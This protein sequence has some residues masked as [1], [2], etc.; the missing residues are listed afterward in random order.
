[1]LLFSSP[2]WS[3]Q[4]GQV[5]PT[6]W[7]T[8][9]TH[10]PTIIEDSRKL[11]FS[12]SKQNFIGVIFSIFTCSKMERSFVNCRR[13][14]VIPS[15]EYKRALIYKNQEEYIE[16]YNIE[17]V[18]PFTFGSLKH[19]IIRMK[20]VPFHVVIGLFHFLANYTIFPNIPSRNENVLPC[21]CS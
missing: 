20:K 5:K 13:V 21:T 1:M 7:G 12:L 16:S 15:L 8:W 3:K 18:D 17:N 14:I 2:N 6:N 4:L 11:I 9:P 10:F 19:F